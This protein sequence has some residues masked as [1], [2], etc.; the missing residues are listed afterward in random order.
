M[1]LSPQARASI[2]AKFNLTA[3]E[4]QCTVHEN[5]C[6]YTLYGTLAKLVGKK[7]NPDPKQHTRTVQTRKHK[8]VSRCVYTCTCTCTCNCM[9]IISANHNSLGCEQPS[10]LDVN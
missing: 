5:T 3:Q 8:H 10:G 7:E 6:V 9:R 2:A 4:V 1:S